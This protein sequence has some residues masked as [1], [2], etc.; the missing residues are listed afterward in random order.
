MTGLVFL[1]CRDSRL[2]P[3]DSGL[4]RQQARLLKPCWKHSQACPQASPVTA[5]KHCGL[6]EKGHFPP[7]KCVLVCEASPSDGGVASPTPIFL[8]TPNRPH[9]RRA[10]DQGRMT[11]PRG[12]RQPRLRMTQLSFGEE[13]TSSFRPSQRAQGWNLPL[14]PPATLAF[15]LPREH[16][17]SSLTLCLLLS[18]PRIFFPWTLTRFMPLLPAPLFPQTDLPSSPFL[19]QPPPPQSLAS[20]ASQFIFPQRPYRHVEV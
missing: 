19:N 12:R 18:L 4:A 9:T 7:G 17:N 2:A 1:M 3:R 13:R 11:Q 10:G 6:Q 20:P 8:F 15:S 5:R 14:M 16:P